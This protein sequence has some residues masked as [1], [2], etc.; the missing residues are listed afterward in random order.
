MHETTAGYSGPVKAEWI[1]ENDHVESGRYRELANTGASALLK[2]AGLDECYRDS[3][4]ATFFQKE[5]RVCF[6]LE[7]RLGDGVEVRSRVVGATARAVHHYHEI[8]RMPEGPRA[9]TVEFLTLHVDRVTR[10][11]APMPD[12][13]LARLRAMAGFHADQPAGN[14]GNRIALR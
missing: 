6:E 14:I 1:D 12:E 4:E 8:F 9:A 10:R 2:K 3:A 13:C 11:T 5:M 7:L